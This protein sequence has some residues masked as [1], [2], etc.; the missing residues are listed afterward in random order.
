MNVSF[1]TFLINGKQGRSQAYVCMQKRPH[2]FRKKKNKTK[3]KKKRKERG[4]R[5]KAQ[6]SYSRIVNKIAKQNP[7]RW[8]LSHIVGRTLHAWRWLLLRRTYVGRLVVWRIY[9]ALCRYLSHIATWKQDITNLSNRS[10]E[11]RESN[12]GPLKILSLWSLAINIEPA[13]IFGL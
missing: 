1:Q 11:T 6:F 4:E 2:R 9:V 12:P 5:A 3:R 7:V 8:P 13:L 10:G